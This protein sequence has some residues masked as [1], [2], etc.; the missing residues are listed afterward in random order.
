MASY[1]L[2]VLRSNSSHTGIE[3]HNAAL[4]FHHSVACSR[5][6]DGRAVEGQ[7]GQRPKGGG[8]CLGSIYISFIKRYLSLQILS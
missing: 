8:G 4:T 7:R 3:I 6:V 1:F 5:K 2:A